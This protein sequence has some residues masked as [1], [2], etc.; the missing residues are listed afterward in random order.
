MRYV[1]IYDSVL[2]RLGQQS[3]PILASSA[4]QASEFVAAQSFVRQVT[5]VWLP[6]MMNRKEA[7]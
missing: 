6:A 3:V 5:A 7:A 2:K 1:V 4:Q